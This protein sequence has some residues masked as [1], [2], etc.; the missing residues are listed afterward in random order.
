MNILK[1][2]T[3][4][5]FL[6]FFIVSPVLACSNNGIKTSEVDTV[7][8]DISDNKLLSY[9]EMFE[10]ILKD[11]YSEK[12]IINIMGENLQTSS[13]V[14]PARDLSYTTLTKTLNVTS[15]YK[16]KIKFY[17]QVD[18]AHGAYYIYRVMDASLI[19]NYNDISKVF[20]GKIYYN[21]ET[22][23]RIYFY[24]NGDFYNYGTI[25]VT[26]GGS[27]GLGQ[28]ASV[29]F[30]VSGSSNHYKYFYTDDYIHMEDFKKI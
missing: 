30:N 28:S 2:F 18:A 9:D 27:I 24:V 3:I 7:D 29:F 5:S 10:E 21:L 4:F 19:K 22:K 12:E 23:T 1:N 13:N 11:G 6:I 26:G 16:P 25:S 8:L 14:Q 20:D 17:I 15:S